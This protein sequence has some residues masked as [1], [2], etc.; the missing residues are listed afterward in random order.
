MTRTEYRKPKRRWLVLLLVAA[1]LAAA[2]LYAV[3]SGLTAVSEEDIR[4]MTAENMGLLLLVMFALMVFQNLVT[5][6]P[7][8][9]ILSVNVALFGLVGG[10]AWSWLTSLVGA[11]AAFAVARY[12]FQDVVTRKLKRSWL[13]KIEQNGF[14]FVFLARLFP[15]APSNLINFTAG[16][17]G[18]PFRRYIASTA[19]GNFLFQLTV[20]LLVEGLLSEGAGQIVSVAVFA[21]LLAAF[22]AYRRF[23]CPRTKRKEGRR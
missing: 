17:S 13:E 11:T 18:V 21:V 20:S 22:L 8:V 5:V 7:L 6:I 3:A 10:F 2:L 4:R 9:A 12:G 1:V 15:F 14:M 23:R 16:V 19:A